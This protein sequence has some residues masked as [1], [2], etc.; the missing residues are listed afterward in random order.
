MYG[1]IYNR[2]E[3]TQL[4]ISHAKKSMSFTIKES[5]I[6]DIKRSKEVIDSNWLL[7][8]CYEKYYSDKAVQCYDYCIY[9]YCLL[10]DHV[11]EKEKIEIQMLLISLMKNK[12][13]LKKD[14]SIMLQ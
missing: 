2:L 11:S 12:A 9:Q 10:S 3:N 7:G 14:E 1:L 13:L 5:N 4:A 6:L 8:R